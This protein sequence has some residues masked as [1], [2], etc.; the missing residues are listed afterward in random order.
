MCLAE[1]NQTGPP[2]TMMDR[3]DLIR[4]GLGPKKIPFFDHGEA[5]E[6][7]DELLLA[8]RTL[9][10]NNREFFVIPPVVTQCSVLLARRKSTCDR[11]RKILI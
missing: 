9:P 1:C 7:H 6:F 5:W 3:V 2:P 4:A 10:N 8:F 11:C